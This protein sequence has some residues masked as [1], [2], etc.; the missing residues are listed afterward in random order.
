MN[1]REAEFDALVEDLAASLAPWKVDPT[2]GRELE[3][4]L[5]GMRGELVGQ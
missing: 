4:A 5:A 1:I 3:A 2:D